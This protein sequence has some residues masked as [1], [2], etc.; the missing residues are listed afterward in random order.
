VQGPPAALCRAKLAGYVRGSRK[1]RTRKTLMR[2]VMLEHVCE[3]AWLLLAE[4]TIQ[5]DACRSREDQR[6]AFYRKTAG[7]PVDSSS[8]IKRKQSC[9]AIDDFAFEREAKHR[10]YSPRFSSELKKAGSD[11]ID[12]YIRCCR[13]Y[14]VIRKFAIRYSQ[15]L[16]KVVPLRETLFRQIEAFTD[17]QSQSPRAFCARSIWSDR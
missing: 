8:S 16:F 4:N 11:A 10:K 14:H 17:V 7:R 3:I 9:R 15:E 12:C 5:C 2:A 1:S 13:L 6:T